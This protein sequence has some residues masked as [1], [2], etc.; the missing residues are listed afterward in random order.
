[1][2][3]A[4]FITGLFIVVVIAILVFTAQEDNK[5]TP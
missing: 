4:A 5:P 1:M 3:T 2:N